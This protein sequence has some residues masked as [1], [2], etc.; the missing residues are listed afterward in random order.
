MSSV[1]MGVSKRRQ[2]G[3]WQKNTDVTLKHGCDKHMIKLVNTVLY[4]D[5]LMT[6]VKI[7]QYI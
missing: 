7:K 1:I 5:M 6:W 4:A 3:S 2:R